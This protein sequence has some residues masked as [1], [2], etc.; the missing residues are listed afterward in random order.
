MKENRSYSDLEAKLKP[1]HA[2]AFQIIIKTIEQ[3]PMILIQSRLPLLKSIMP[4]RAALPF[5]VRLQVC[6]A[7]V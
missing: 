1:A 4:L 2:H 3:I 7:H 6:E 5:V